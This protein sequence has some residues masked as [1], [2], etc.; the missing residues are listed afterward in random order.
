MSS[1]ATPA[2]AVERLSK[3]FRLGVRLKKV[4]AVRDITFAAP[5]GHVFGFLGPNGAGK[6]TTIKMCMGL[7][8]PS[9]G[10]VRVLGEPIASLAVRAR[11]GYLPEQPYFYDYLKPHEILDFYARLFGMDRAARRR[12]VGELLELVGLAD[13]RERTL[14]KFSKGMLQRVGIAQ[15]LINDPELVVLDE[16][17]SGL[18]P[19]GRK[20]IRDII[21]DLRRR[22]KTVFFSSHILADIE[23]ICD[24]VAIINK[25]V[26]QAAGRLSDLLNPRLMTAE[27]TWRRGDADLPQRVETFGAK[28]D[29]L[30]AL[31]RAVVEAPRSTE[32]L[33]LLLDGGAEVDGVVPKRDSLEDLFMREA[34]KTGGE[35]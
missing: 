27:V 31:W 15:A 8:R 21:V 3:T 24:E 11:I 18:D 1:G 14:R 7:I 28:V 33:R 25:G 17:L 30:G 22:G 5:A 20:E 34:L 35:P 23:M 19:I 4:E 26:I 32:L 9:A 6:T 10:T 2:I 13:A 16:P 29:D 12:R